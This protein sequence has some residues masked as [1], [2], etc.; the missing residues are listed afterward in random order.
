MF[1]FSFIPSP[2]PYNTK[3]FGGYEFIKKTLMFF[4]Y[5]AFNIFYE[6]A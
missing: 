6:T 2:T 4:Y 5:C 3:G 1:I